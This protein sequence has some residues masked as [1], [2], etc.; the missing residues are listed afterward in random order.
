MKSYIE[1][2]AALSKRT[3]L[4]P[5]LAS[6]ILAVILWAYITNT[7][8]GD[9][10]FNIPVDFRNIDETLILSQVSQRTATVKVS[11]RKDD[12]KNVNARD[13]ILF[14]DLSKVNIG[15]YSDYNIEFI[16]NEVP[17]GININIQPDT[18]KVLVEQKIS[19]E[20]KIIPK[21]I[22]NAEKGFHIG[23][24]K[25]FPETV[26]LRGAPSRLN[27]IESIFTEGIALEGNR[28]D[29]QKKVGIQ[30]FDLEGIEYSTES[31]TAMVPVIS[32]SDVA[33]L[34][35][36][37]SIKNSRRG[38]K[39]TLQSGNVNIHIILDKKKRASDYKLTAFVDMA[40]FGDN[41][42]ELEKKDKIEWTADV[43]LGGDIPDLKER[44][45]SITPD[46][47]LLV[48]TKE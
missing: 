43:Q 5:K 12:L 15:E 6:I 31:V 45:I 48:I 14:V 35:I 17:E 37:V 34:G 28:E 26:I 41:Y 3:N 1:S 32:Y 7:R 13:I 24:V 21:F 2:F 10:R 44:A 40:D 39:Y 25:L 4:V 8:S 36:P 29:I 47:I 30:K 22:G 42:S 16:R 27:E 46:K 38:Y 9:V 19:K 18:V 20:I 23:K 11:G 33:Q